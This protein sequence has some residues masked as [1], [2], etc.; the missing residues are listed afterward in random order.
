[1]RRK[2]YLEGISHGLA[3]RYP[4]TSPKP[5]LITRKICWSADPDGSTVEIRLKTPINEFVRFPEEC[6]VMLYRFLL[7]NPRYEPGHAEAYRR[8]PYLPYRRNIVAPAELEPDIDRNVFL[9]PLI[10]FRAFFNRIDVNIDGIR[11]E[12]SNMDPIMAIHYQALNRLLCSEGLKRAKYPDPIRVIRHMADLVAGTE[13]LAS[14]EAPLVYPADI[15]CGAVPLRLGYFGIDGCFPFGTQNNTLR[16]LTKT[17][18]DQCFFK[19]G[20][21]FTFILHRT[22]PA[23]TFLD[24]NRPTFTQFFYSQ[25]L[26]DAAQNG[27]NFRLE[28]TRLG[29]VYESLILDRNPE[30]KAKLISLNSKMVCDKPYYRIA[31]IT[32][33]LQYQV[34][35]FPIERHTRLLYFVFLTT[36]QIKNDSREGSF[37]GTRY[38]F[39]DRLTNMK[40]RLTNYEGL[41]N[42]EGVETP[43]PNDNADH[44][45]S[46]GLRLLHGEMF[47][48]GLTNLSFAEWSPS[49]VANQ[50]GFCK[51][52]V[53]DL[54]PYKIDEPT[55]LSVE[56]KFNNAGSR[57][58]CHGVVFGVQQKY[59]VHGEGGEPWKEYLMS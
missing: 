50:D 29:L 53:L 36:S 21:E 1:M 5:D 16:Q 30:A 58:L 31:N 9:N 10:G 48:N 27:C 6:F 47:K 55:E 49:G 15:D 22:N 28:T 59:F 37:C 54:T 24:S 35:K 41:V 39:L 11:L 13:S 7:Q 2:R 14:A 45:R 4:S 46:F 25:A 26:P 20:T 17:K 42:Y 19:P 12:D 18:F 34:L 23:R 51:A 52:V 57:N 40:F 8:H 43:G 33:F 44:A 32:A 56:L 3:S 38:H